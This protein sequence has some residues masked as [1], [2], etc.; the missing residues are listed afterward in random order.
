MLFL[1]FGVLVEEQMQLVEGVAPHQPVVLLV[2]AVKDD[3]VGQELIE[4]LRTLRPG[5]RAR[6]RSACG[7]TRRTPGL[8]STGDGRC[9]LEDARFRSLFWLPF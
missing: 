5:L 7:V 9:W 6:A 1:L 3:A 8:S 4:Q 2:Q